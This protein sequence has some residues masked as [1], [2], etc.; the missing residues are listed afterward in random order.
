MSGP[1]TITVHHEEPGGTANGDYVYVQ[2]ADDP[3]KWGM[4]W[5]SGRV[6]AN[7]L[8][9]RDVLWQLALAIRGEHTTAITIAEGTSELVYRPLTARGHWR[10]TSEHGGSYQKPGE[11]LWE[12]AE[13]VVERV[14]ERVEADT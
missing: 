12:L 8:D 11:L 14:E 6:S 10:G 7:V 3:F 4:S 5:P 1:L 2:R 9:G 13:L